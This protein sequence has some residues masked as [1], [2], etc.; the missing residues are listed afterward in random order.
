MI[1]HLQDLVMGFSNGEW[2]HGPGISIT[3]IDNPGWGI[4]ICLNGTPLVEL[5]IE[6]VSHNRSEDDWIFIRTEMRAFEKY[7]MAACGPQNLEETLE[8]I[9]SLLEQERPGQ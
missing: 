1:S 6:E 2:E 9:F 4:D 5:Q 3:T 7:L 8:R